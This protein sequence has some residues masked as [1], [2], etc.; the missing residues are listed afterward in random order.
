MSGGWRTNFPLSTISDVKVQFRYRLDHA[1]NYEMDE[2]SEILLSVDSTLRATSGNDYIAKVT[3]DGQGGSLQST[4]WQLADIPI[5]DLAIGSHDITIGG[6]NNKKTFTDEFTDIYIDDV[7][8]VVTT[9]PPSTSSTSTT[10]TSTTTSPASVTRGPYLQIG[11]PTSMSIKWRTDIAKSSRVAYGTTLSNLFNCV[12]ETNITTDHEITVTGLVADTEYFY[13]IGTLLL[14]LAGNDTNHTFVSA[15]NIGQSKPTRIWVLGDSGTADANAAAVRDSYTTFTGTTRTDIWLMLGDNAYDSGTDNEYQ[16]AVFDMY[17]SILRRTPLWPTLGNHDGFT[18]DSSTESGPYYDIFSL[19][20]DGQAGGLAS[21]TEAY[22]SFD[23]ANIHFICL[24]SYETDRSTNG[25]MLTWLQNDLSQTLQDWIIAFWHHPP[26][27]KGSHDSD[28][29]IEL[30]EMRENAIPILEAGGV[31]LVLTGHSHAYERSF[32]LHA[33][34]GHS[35]TLETNS[36][37]IDEGDGRPGAD[38]AYTRTTSTGTVYVVAGSSGEL[39]PPYHGLDHPAMFL[40][41]AELGSLV[42]DVDDETLDATF[43]DDQGAIRDSFSIIHVP[44]PPAP[45][46]NFSDTHQTVHV[47]MTIAPLSN[48]AVVL[49]WNGISGAVYSIYQ[50]TNLLCDWPGTLVSNAI[51]DTTS[52][53]SLRVSTN[54]VAPAA[55]YTIG[56]DEP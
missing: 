8:V 44:P 40:S 29:E 9:L 13:S 27:S 54:H 12:T 51:S 21:G 18:A 50:S 23:Y 7:T 26:Y 19:P 10:S 35:S 52:P 28:N 20:R 6:Y 37:V 48:D 31:D 49:N 47:T 17:P 5:H 2:Y 53:M 4:G 1:A 15:P 22:Y 16:A 33:H 43:I 56:V 14:D 36:M 46:F 32:Y 25:T 42:V 45:G 38:G 39:E 34:Y 24:E 11:T 30:M 41:F 55:F 3:G